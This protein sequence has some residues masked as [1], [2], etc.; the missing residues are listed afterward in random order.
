MGLPCPKNTAGI[1]DRAFDIPL[2]SALASFS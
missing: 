1:L 2:A